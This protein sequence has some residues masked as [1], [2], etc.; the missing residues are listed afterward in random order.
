VVP[1]AIADKTIAE[2]VPFLEPGDILTDGGNP[3]HVE[4][5][6]YLHCGPNGAGRFCQNGLL[7][8]LGEIPPFLQMIAGTVGAVFWLLVI[9]PDD[10]HI[11][12]RDSPF[13]T[14]QND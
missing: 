6:A 5:L 13:L 11:R 2:F 14:G 7:L 1:T 10:R 3:Y 12:L 8:V 9:V 4:E